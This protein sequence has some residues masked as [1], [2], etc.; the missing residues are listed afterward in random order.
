MEFLHNNVFKSNA[1]AVQLVKE[2]VD[3]L[4]KELEIERSVAE[5][6]LIKHNVFFHALWYVNNFRATWEILLLTYYEFKTIFFLK[7]TCFY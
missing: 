2:D 3:L 5:H 1:S 6:A 7:D 4:V